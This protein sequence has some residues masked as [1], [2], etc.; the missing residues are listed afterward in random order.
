MRP[1]R[2]DVQLYVPPPDA[3][4]RLEV[5]KVHTSG[6]PLAAD[7]DLERLAADTERFSGI[8]SDPLSSRGLIPVCRS[9]VQG[10]GR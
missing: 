2:L 9:G 7:V 3:E 8:L 6:M 5:L 4:G 10:L 1:G